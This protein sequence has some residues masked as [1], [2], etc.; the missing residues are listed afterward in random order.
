M[1]VFPVARILTHQLRLP[2]FGV[3]CDVCVMC[4][5]RLLEHHHEERPFAVN[6]SDPEKIA[7]CA[8]GE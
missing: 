6:R 8:S 2:A 5:L 4:N 3:E 7:D 1:L